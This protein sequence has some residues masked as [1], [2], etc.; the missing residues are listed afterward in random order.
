MAHD[1]PTGSGNSI[2][3]RMNRQEQAFSQLMERLGDLPAGY[4][5]VADL[6]E[7]KAISTVL[8]EHIRMVDATLDSLRATHSF[9]IGREVR[10]LKLELKEHGYR[11]KAVNSE[12]QPVLGVVSMELTLGLWSGK[13]SLMAVPLDEFDLN[14]GRSSWL[15][16]KSFQFHIWTA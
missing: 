1:I 2:L 7:I 9:V 14:W 13:C 6:R 12:A 15:Q 3:E 16:T 5:L 10:R 8:R 11:I 4:V